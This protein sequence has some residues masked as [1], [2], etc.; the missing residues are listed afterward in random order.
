MKA[1]IVRGTRRLVVIVVVTEPTLRSSV[2]MLMLK[3]RFVKTYLI[4]F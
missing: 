3:A 1:S 2:R 4:K